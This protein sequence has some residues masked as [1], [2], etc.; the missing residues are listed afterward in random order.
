[1]A[2]VISFGPDRPDDPDEPNGPGRP[3]RAIPRWVRVVGVVGSVVLV[4]GAAVFVSTRERP[5]EAAPPDAGIVVPTGPPEAALS[6]SAAPESVPPAC[7]PVGWGQEPPVSGAVAALRIDGMPRQG[8]LDR[9]DR[10]VGDGPWTVVVRR[11]DGSLGRHGAVVTFPAEPVVGG[12]AV[13]V[14]PVAGVVGTGTVTWPVAGKQARVRGDLPEDQLIAIAAATRVDN[15]RPSVNP[16]AG[17]TVV[18]AG[19]YRSPTIHDMRYGSDS[20][21]E[22]AALGNGLTYTAVGSGGGFEDQ[23]YATGGRDGAP[24][25]GRPSV[26]LPSFGGS[27]AIA[28]EPAPGVVAYVGYSGSLPDDAA[29]AAL[30]RLAARTRPVAGAEWL[31]AG[32]SIVDQTNTPG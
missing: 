26:V 4:V 1:M 15:G 22:S 20:V 23:I 9:C 14:G 27:G 10:A 24:V 6:V 7:W 25:D 11:P 17:V 28:W 5:E 16:P 3:R 8:G 12:R 31:E 32:A 30:Q 19:P 29:I 18:T 2:D 21:G 13:M